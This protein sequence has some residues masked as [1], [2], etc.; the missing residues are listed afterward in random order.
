[1]RN[2][3]ILSGIFKF[4]LWFTLIHLFFRATRQ[5]LYQQSGYGT[6]N[7]FMPTF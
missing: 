1:M 4:F 2:Q 7:V 5:K 6:K 3:V